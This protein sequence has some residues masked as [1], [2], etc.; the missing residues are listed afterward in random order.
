[1]SSEKLIIISSEDKD[2]DSSTSN[3]DFVVNL[4]EK[5]YTQNVLKTLVKE[6]TVPN[7]FPNI[8]G[9]DYGTSQNNIIRFLEGAVQRT[10]ILPEGQYI[11]S[12]I[13]ATPPDPWDFVA[14]LNILI[15]AETATAVVEV[16]YNELTNKLEFEV[17]AG[18]DVTFQ[19]NADGSSIISDV[20]GLTNSLF[21][22]SGLGSPLP[23]QGTVQLSGYQNVY[24][25][26]KEI[27]DTNAIDGD[28]GLISVVEPISLADT[29]YN[30]YAYKMNCDDELA[31]I[32]YEQPRNLSRIRVTLRDN[33]GNV[34]PIGTAKIN[35][36]L[37]SY[38]AS[39]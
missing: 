2:N 31:Q 17:T 6:A 1:M 30:S 4:K 8:R 9:E 13:T 22:P 32:L 33:L 34:L 35:F 37:K 19:T 27:A 23:A 28:F 12:A 24:L 25:H 16:T 36:V 5:Y 39:G 21:V 15:N 7:V 10:A 38:L 3:S 20:L 29:E 18:A 11:I 14:Q 26:S